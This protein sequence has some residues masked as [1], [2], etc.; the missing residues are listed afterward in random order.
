MIGD[1]RIRFL[2]VG[3]GAAIVGILPGGRRAFVVDVFNA[4]RVLDFLDTEGIAEV[5]VFLTHSD[6]DHTQGAQDLLVGL[7]TRLL[8]IF[9]SQDRINASKGGDY[10]RL[11]QFI[12]QIERRLTRNDPRNPSAHF[13]TAL[14]LMPAFA[15]LF[16]PVRISVVHPSKADQDS[17]IGVNTNETSG[18]LLLEHIIKDNII[19]RALLPGDVQLTGISLLMDRE[20]HLPIHADVLMFPHHGAWPTAW[21]GVQAIG[22]GFT[23]RTMAEFINRVMPSIIVFSVGSNN[24]FG[25]VRPEVLALL[26]AYQSESGRLRMIRWTQLTPA[27]TIP[28]AFPVNCAWV[29]PAGAGDIEIQMGDYPSD[30]YVKVQ[31]AGAV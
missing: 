10:K 3:Q 30:D 18:V 23:Q 22:P 19:R 27:C 8:A 1:L 20:N 9:F 24:Q 12:G 11:V 5:V 31:S 4:D 28:G 17:Q 7:S 29:E 6:R 16:D 21:P 2:D 13:N 26:N 25:H 15:S 14:N